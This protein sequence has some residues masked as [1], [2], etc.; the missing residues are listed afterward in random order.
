[1]NERQTAAKQNQIHV[2]FGVSSSEVYMD[3]YF[4]RIILSESSDGGSGAGTKS[5]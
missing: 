4:S 2:N 5:E 1:M 3:F